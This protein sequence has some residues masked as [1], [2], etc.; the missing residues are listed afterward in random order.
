MPFRLSSPKPKV[1]EKH[2]ADQIKQSLLRR[3]WIPIRQQSGLFKTPDGRFVA[4]GQKGLADYIVMHAKFPA[5]FLETKRPKRHLSDQQ[6]I[7][8][9]EYDAY[10][11]RTCK[12]D[13]VEEILAFLE[14]H[15]ASNVDRTEVIERA[16]AC[17]RTE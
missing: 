17:E 5:F 11:L 7:K 4:V 8:R 9:W 16:S 10:G 13:S 3:G 15:E 6:C 2:V 1:L 14:R 12:A